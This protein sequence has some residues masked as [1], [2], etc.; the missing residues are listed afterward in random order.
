MAFLCLQNPCGEEGREKVLVGEPTSWVLHWGHAAWLT[1]VRS[2]VGGTPGAIYSNA[3]M[4]QKETRV[5][6]DMTWYSD[7][8]CHCQP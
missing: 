1:G 5:R 3:L 2:D 8:T 4:L 6:G 7:P